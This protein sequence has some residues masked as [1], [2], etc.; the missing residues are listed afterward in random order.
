M[1]TEDSPTTELRVGGWVPPPPQSPAGYPPLSD[2]F[3][4]AAMATVP[5]PAAE[6]G[7][8]AV[9]RRRRTIA[10]CAACA[11][12]LVTGTIAWQS[13]R[14]G[15]VA[16]PQFVT[17]PSVPTVPALPVAPPTASASAGASLSVSAAASVLHPSSAGASAPASAPA[18]A[19]A[20]PSPAPGSSRTAKPTT[21]APATKAPTTSG[22]FR[23]GT[24]VSLE[25]ADYPG[26]LVRHRNFR[27]RVDRISSRS[28]DLDHADSRFVVRAGLADAA[29]VSFEAS[30][31]AGYYLR[32]RN[33]EVWLDQRSG[34]ALYAADATFCPAG[35]RAGPVTLHPQNYPDQALAVFRSEIGLGTRGTAFAVRSPF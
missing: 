20:P 23:I 26:Y 2:S 16:A 12:L 10:A 31:Y 4:A 21:G 27:A 22:P 24:A 3:L 6:P 17:L 9:P 28:S 25:V 14:P 8:T 19:S 29:C 15:A 5:Q 33:G 11:V 30:N 1:S 13:S 32:H 7:S 18:S 35:G 34:S